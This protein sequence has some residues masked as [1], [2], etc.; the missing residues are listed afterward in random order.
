MRPAT[1]SPHRRVRSARARR[2]PNVNVFPCRRA[3]PIWSSSPFYQAV[4][5]A[6]GCLRPFRGFSK[7]LRYLLSNKAFFRARENGGKLP[8][9]RIRSRRIVSSLAAG[10][11]VAL[12]SGDAVLGQSAPP[13]VP[14]NMSP[15]QA[16]ALRQMLGQPPASSGQP[17][18]TAPRRLLPSSRSTRRTRC[19]PRE[20]VPTTFAS[21]VHNLGGRQR[22]SCRQRPDLARRVRSCQ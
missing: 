8:V 20:S 19:A 5:A 4:K 22:N 3:S 1:H 10:L 12:V 7:K 15:E 13:S 2:P 14:A 11:V 21:S 6:P 16:D 18:V 17:V 9:T